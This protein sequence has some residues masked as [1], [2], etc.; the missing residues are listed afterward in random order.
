MSELTK[1]YKFIDIFLAG[2]SYI[3]GTGII[4][5]LPFIIGKAKGNTWLAFLLGGI[6]SIFT[7]LSYA[8]L[9]LEIPSNDAEY[10]WIIKSFTTDKDEK[11]NNK[12]YKRVK[13][14]STII[15]YAVMFF[16]IAMNS[17]L[18]VS[19]VKLL[20][21][22]FINPEMSNNI[23]NGLILGIPALI[24]IFLSKYTSVLNN[25]VSV[26][27]TIGL[28]TVV[29]FGLFKNKI[30]GDKLKDI[31]SGDGNKFLFEKDN[32]FINLFMGVFLTIYT[33]NGF[34]SIVQMSEEAK[35][36]SDIPKAMIGSVSVSIFIYI[37][38]AIS[39]ISIFG[40]KN[41]SNKLAPIVDIFSEYKPGLTKIIYLIVVIPAFTNLLLSMMSR[42]RLLKK[43]SE[44]KLAPSIFKEVKMDSPIYSVLLVG[45]VS[46]LLTLISGNSKN[47]PIET[48][49]S[50]SNIFAFFVFFCINIAVIYKHKKQNKNSNTTS[51]T[52]TTS[53]SNTEEDEGKIIKFLKNTYPYYGI[54][55]AVFS[56]I[57][58]ILSSKDFI[59]KS[60]KK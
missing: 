14:L 16:G 23:L 30:Y 57:F 44:L 51:T 45:I 22:S 32:S 11:D 52:S 59:N 28:V 8:K 39:I 18:S 48:L 29:L 56:F 55:G 54:L 21:K 4:T 53:A 6:I 33:Y 46:Y 9:N 37:A 3:V 50:I 20:K 10:S 12:K 26:F 49:A 34:Q 60:K 13:L 19:I 7:G 42:S 58:I 1:K 40:V 2:Y 24:N 41:S 47:N 5:I 27:T 15:I 31:F 35:D 17:T 38:V 25:S 43:L 36:K